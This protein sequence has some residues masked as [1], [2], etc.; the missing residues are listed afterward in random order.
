MTPTSIQGLID[1][2]NV[3]QTG[4]VEWTGDNGLE[5][6]ITYINE[7]TVNFGV[8]TVDSLAQL[9][10]LGSSDANL[11]SVKAVGLYRFNANATQAMPTSVQ[12]VGG[13]WDLETTYAA[14][15]KYQK[16][17]GN[18]SST[19][20]NFTHNLGIQYPSVTVWLLI[21]VNPEMVQTGYEVFSTGLNSVQL[22]FDVAPTYNSYLINI[23]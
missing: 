4:T 2:A 16:V 6:I 21:G 15:S 18:G 12:G 11:V 20:F 13:I 10:L 3:T 23:Q 5:N 22:V 8:K 7:N 1:T 14:V 9:A 17:F 19:T